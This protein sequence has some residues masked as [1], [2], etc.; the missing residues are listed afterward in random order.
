MSQWLI[1]LSRQ[2]L[3]PKVTWLIPLV[4][5]RFVLGGTSP[6]AN[7]WKVGGTREIS[8]PVQQDTLHYKKNILFMEYY[9][10]NTANEYENVKKKI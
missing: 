4:L 3:S 6:Q 5:Q 2:D 8:T 9:G 1:D 10:Y 7:A